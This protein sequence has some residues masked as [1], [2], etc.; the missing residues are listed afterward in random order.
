MDVDDGN[1]VICADIPSIEEIQQTLVNI[2]DKPP[3]FFGSCDWLGA[4]E[5]GELFYYINTFRSRNLIENIPNR[6]FMW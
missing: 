6:F 4:L 1:S 3:E 2:N 5:V